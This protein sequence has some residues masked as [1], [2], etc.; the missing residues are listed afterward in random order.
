L[1]FFVKFRLT[2]LDFRKFSLISFKIIYRLLRRTMSKKKTYSYP[3]KKNPIILPPSFV[4]GSVY[5]VKDQLIEIQKRIV[6]NEKDFQRKNDKIPAVWF[7]LPTAYLPEPFVSSWCFE[8][9]VLIREALRHGIIKNRH[10][11]H[12]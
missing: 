6:A 7:L 4:S 9:F 8:C 12:F 10:D 2:V 5:S 3:S 11:T 1:S